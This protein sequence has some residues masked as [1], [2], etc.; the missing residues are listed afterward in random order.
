M[1][2]GTSTSRLQYYDRNATD[3]SINYFNAALAPAG[4]TTRASY[5]VPANRAARLEGA[6]A[7]VR[8]ITAAAP[9]GLYA[10]QVQLQPGGAGNDDVAASFNIGNA[11]DNG[12]AVNAGDA[13]HLV[14]ADKIALITQDASTGGTV[15]FDLTAKLT[16]FDA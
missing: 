7:L 4:A 11:I 5:T 9:V 1:L 6:M 14:A 12:Y 8:R 16:E 3:V 10:G 2:K 13:G 15:L